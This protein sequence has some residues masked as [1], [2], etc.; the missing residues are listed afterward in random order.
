MTCETCFNPRTRVGCDTTTTTISHT[1]LLFQSTHPRGVRRGQRRV[2]SLRRNVSIHAPA[3]GATYFLE[4]FFLKVYSFNPRTR[5]G[6]DT[7]HQATS[8]DSVI[9]SIH[10]PAWGATQTQPLSIR[11]IMFQSTHPRGVRLQHIGQQEVLTK[12]SIHAPAWGAT[13][14]SRLMRIPSMVSI[15]APAWGATLRRIVERYHQEMFQSTHPRGVRPCC[16]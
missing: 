1:K 14:K 11:Q 2:E 12:V 15:H 9:V 4:C 3:W 6:C 7:R 8:T 10:A 13:R 16:E 5:V